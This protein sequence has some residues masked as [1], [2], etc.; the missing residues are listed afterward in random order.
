M[1]SFQIACPCSATESHSIYSE[2]SGRAAEK[3][4]SETGFLSAKEVEEA[5]PYALRLPTIQWIHQDRP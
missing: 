3:P 1:Q 2:E 4:Y 5:E